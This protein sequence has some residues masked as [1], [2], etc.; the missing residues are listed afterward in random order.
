M[1]VMQGR[2]AIVTGAA[3]GIG[4]ATALALGEAGANVVLSDFGGGVDGSGGGQEPVAE[5]AAELAQRGAE[6]LQDGG[7]VTDEAKVQALFERTLERFGHVDALVNCAGILRDRMIFSMT[8]DE[9][10]GVVRVHLRGHFLVTAAA[11]RH[12][13]DRSKAQGAPAGGRVVCMS[14]EAG[15]YGHTGQANY[16][17]AKAGIVG[18]GITVA[19]EMER[20]GVSCNVIAPR[21]RTRMTEGAFG[22][23][24]ESH[25]WDP[26]NIAPLVVYL[27]SEAGG[28][29]SGQIFVVGGGVLQHVAHHAVSR[30]IEVDPGPASHDEVAAFVQEAVG[31]PAQPPPF[32]DLGLPAGVG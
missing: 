12:W 8:P 24:G 2:T 14:S 28:A 9:W 6:V 29:C 19:R 3:R 17:A 16:A 31:L 7:D 27:L 20:Y 5:V 13:R 15:L 26:E 18:F 25:R 32:P 23:F 21:A 30:E 11:C 1:G 10:D 22:N 4:R